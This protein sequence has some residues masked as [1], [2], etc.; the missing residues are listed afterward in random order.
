VVWT[1]DPRGTLE[2]AI[3]EPALVSN[4]GFG[5]RTA[6]CHICTRCGV[7]PVV[8]SRIDGALYAVISVNWIPSVRYRAVA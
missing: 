7:V 8:T 2:I 1:S 4:Y 5:T 3:A 6:E